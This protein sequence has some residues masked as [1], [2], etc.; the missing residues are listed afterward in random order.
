MSHPQ[1]H[2]S[3]AWRVFSLTVACVASRLITAGPAAA[4]RSAPKSVAPV[5]A[6]TVEYSA[7]PEVTGFVI[8]TYPPTCMGELGDCRAPTSVPMIPP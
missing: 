7:P 6:G 1:L 3:F 5:P 4:K 2:T 8:A